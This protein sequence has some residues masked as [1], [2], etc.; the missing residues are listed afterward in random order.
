LGLEHNY[1]HLGNETY[2]NS[3]SPVEVSDIE[4]IIAI[5]SGENESLEVMDDGTVCRAV[6][7]LK[8]ERGILS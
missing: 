1:S 7:N 5:G 3:S 8:R 6:L 4:G 2:A